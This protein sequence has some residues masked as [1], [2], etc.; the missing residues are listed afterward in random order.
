MFKE[1]ETKNFIEK[2]SKI[3][4]DYT[5]YEI[6][7][8]NKEA[9]NENQY[10]IPD[11]KALRESLEISI[12]KICSEVDIDVLDLYKSFVLNQSSIYYYIVENT[13]II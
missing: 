7:L 4:V 11:E 6:Y 1:I 5:K 8:A 9:E 2:F 12:R 3:L 13:P 10:Y